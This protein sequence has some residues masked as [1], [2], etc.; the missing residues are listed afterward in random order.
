MQARA[1]STDHRVTRMRK[2]LLP[3]ERNNGCQPV[4]KYPDFSGLFSGEAPTK[5][6]T[7]RQL[8]M[9]AQSK[10]SQHSPHIIPNSTVWYNIF[11][12]FWC[13]FIILLQNK[14]LYPCISG[15]LPLNS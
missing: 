8:C 4:L 11:T 5:H 3:E 2:D 9:I 1:A 14:R 12:I 13:D 6:Q 10:S 15:F 7:F